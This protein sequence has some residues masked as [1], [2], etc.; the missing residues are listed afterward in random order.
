MALKRRSKRHFG[1]R[2]STFNACCF[3]LAAILFSYSILAESPDRL[4]QASRA[5]LADQMNAITSVSAS[6]PENPYNTLAKQLDDKTQELN[7]REAG[8][9]ATE[10]ALKTPNLFA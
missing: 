10:Q 3:A 5:L 2:V 8:I 4:V 7:T 1:K 9:A 6:V